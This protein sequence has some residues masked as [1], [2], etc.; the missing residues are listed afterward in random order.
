MKYLTTAPVQAEWH[1]RTGY[2]AIHPVAYEEPLVKDEWH[3][4]LQLKVT[5]D[6]LH[7]T[8]STPA[9]QG[10]LITVFPESRQ[11]IVKAMERLYEG[12]DAQ[13]TLNKAVEATSRAL[14][15]EN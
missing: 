3:R 10:A 15:G 11:R 4:Y 6:Q 8:K 14:Q 5:V 1:V 2:F 13:D 12:V 9:T 7:G